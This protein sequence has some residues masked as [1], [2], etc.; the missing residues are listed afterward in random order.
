MSEKK[1]ERVSFQFQSYIILKLSKYV[2]ING[3]KKNSFVS[4]NT[5]ISW[6][7]K[8]SNGGNHWEDWQFLLLIYC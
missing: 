5:H 6:Q 4:F 2:L 8:Y 1:R 3:L 7:A